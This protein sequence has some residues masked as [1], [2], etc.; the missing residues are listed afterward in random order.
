[1]LLIVYGNESFILVWMDDVGLD[2]LGYRVDIFGT[3]CNLF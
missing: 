2:V 3:N 1:M